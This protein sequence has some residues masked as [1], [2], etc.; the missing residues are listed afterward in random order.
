MFDKK[1]RIK[2]LNRT[3]AG[4]YVLSLTVPQSITKH[5]DELKDKDLRLEL[6]VWR[7]K[8]SLDANAYFHV[9]VGKIAEKMT[10]PFD[11]VKR[12]MVLSYGTL[13]IDNEGN[14][15]GLKLLPSVDVDKIID[16]AKF[17]KTVEDNGIQFNCYL[18]FEHTH[19]YDTAQMANLIKGVIQEAEDL[20]I[21]TITPAEKERLLR[22]WEERQ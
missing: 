19:N 9:L 21:E 1:C 5:Y 4:E 11:K 2:D 14:N 15:V 3:M 8:R 7:E 6:K 13:S 20:G 22:L 16:Y 18:I 17:V 12:D 10:L